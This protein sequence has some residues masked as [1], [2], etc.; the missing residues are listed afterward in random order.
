M[1]A[2]PFL[3]TH[4]WFQENCVIE[5][6]RRT[7]ITLL[8][9]LQTAMSYTNTNE[10]NIEIFRETG[11]IILNRLIEEGFEVSADLM[12]T[13]KL[14]FQSGKTMIKPPQNPGKE[15]PRKI[16]PMGKV[17]AWNE[18]LLAIE[19]V[20]FAVKRTQCEAK[21]KAFHALTSHNYVSFAAW[22]RVWTHT[23]AI[24]E[25]SE[26]SPF[27]PLVDCAKKILLELRENDKS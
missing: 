16:I 2:D 11:E 6:P 21:E 5:I 12:N 8:T 22:A 10:R 14:T 20:R 17:P 18:N 3:N 1:E 19:D 24:F 27:A 26:P 15:K 13:Y 7:M 23:N 25:I 9:L 4:A